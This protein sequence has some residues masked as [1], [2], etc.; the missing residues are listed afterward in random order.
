MNE[1]Q[2]FKGH[3]EARPIYN[4]IRRAVGDL[5]NVEIR[6]AKSQIGFYREHPFASVWIPDRYLRGERKRWF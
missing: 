5:A 6:V 1:D 4:A 3:E 2:F